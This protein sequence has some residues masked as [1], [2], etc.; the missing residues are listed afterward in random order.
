MNKSPI[1]VT[2]AHAA[3]DAIGVALA[4]SRPPSGDRL[5][6]EPRAERRS[7]GV[8]QG[9][10]DRR[11]TGCRAA[12]PRCIQA[13]SGCRRPAIGNLWESPADEPVAHDRPASR[14]H[15][16]GS[17]GCVQLNQRLHRSG[18]EV[19]VTSFAQRNSV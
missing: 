18:C 14:R 8:T 15:R 11:L 10:A 2:A 9:A 5:D 1:N 3:Q 12:A 7:R 13:A 16:V 6:T 19:T 17:R 4:R